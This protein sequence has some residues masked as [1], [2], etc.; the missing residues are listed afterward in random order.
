[1]MRRTW[2]RRSAVAILI[3]ASIARGEPVR[4][5]WLVGGP[6]DTVA[7][8]CAALSGWYAFADSFEDNVEVYDID[9]QQPIRTITKQEIQALVPGGLDGGPNGPCALAWSDS[10]RIL[11]ILV[12]NLSIDGIIAY[13]TATDTMA[14]FA[15]LP[16]YN[17]NCWPHLAAVH[18]RGRLYVGTYRQGIEVYQ[19]GANDVEGTL[20]YAVT[21]PTG[22][23]VHGLAVDREAN[24]LYA[25]DG[26]NIYRA[27]L[28][29]DP[30]QSEAFVEVGSI[31]NVVA[32]TFSDH[33]GG[34]GNEGLYVL[35]STFPFASAPSC[36][37]D[38]DYYYRLHH[39]PIAQARGQEPFK[40]TVYLS[41]SESLHDIAATACGRLVA[42][43]SENAY[44][45]SDDT[46]TS[47]L[48][49]ES[50]L[51]DEFD[52]VVNFGKS[53]IVPDDE[54]LPACC[55][56]NMPAGW[57][58]DAD[59]Q[60][61]WCRFHPVTPDGAAW[62]TLLL[63]MNEQ[64]NGDPEAKHLV[65]L[66]LERYAGMAEDGIVPES[67]ADGHF[68]HW[69]DPATGE[70]K[71][72]LPECGEDPKRPCWDPEFAVLSTMKMVVAASRA[73][74][75]YPDDLR[76]QS[77][78]LRL[79]CQVKNWD[80]Y[81]EPGTDCLFLKALAEGGPDP[82]SAVCPF[83]E[84]IIFVE[85]AANYGG[86]PSQEAFARWLDR[87]L[88]PSAE[89]VTGK[90]ITGNIPDEFQSAFV[91]LYPFLLQQP[92][93]ASPDWQAQIHNMRCSYA[94]WTDDNG[95]KYYTV[96]SAGTTKPEWSKNGSG[97]NAD[98]LSNHP[99]DI[100]TFPSLMA[101]CATG[102]SPEAVAAYHAYRHAARQTFA[103]GASILYRR[104]DEDPGYKPNSAGLPDVALGALGLAELLQPGS[105]DAVLALAYPALN[106][107][108][109]DGVSDCSDVCPATPS[110]V[111]AVDDEGRPL[112]D[113]DHD[114]DADLLDFRLFQASFTGPIYP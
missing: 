37:P 91:S 57:V 15:E 47:R 82:S 87:G 62:V 106:D 113:L 54:A 31:T 16:L 23:Y 46:D 41:G 70:L 4:E 6:D 19:A 88:W 71:C 2:R 20:L 29:T 9:H 38:P 81:I 33:Y 111:G 34:T 50:W 94:A 48:S 67:S 93:R 102:K 21:L 80:A 101:L 107:L 60:Q 40:P 112:G 43:R 42:G 75:R 73:M 77:A 32:I 68:R 58:V 72:P 110:D 85:Q 53:L 45:I 13:N 98:N 52:Q 44:L 105:V 25:T 92:Y 79:I 99:G 22:S 69:M 17:R 108:D 97:Y 14:L 65:R 74:A 3:C 39:V 26:S 114:C 10:G 86:T 109:G 36:L 18:F 76:I 66:I 59:V 8:A 104:S 64:I 5:T 35:E 83:F 12:H 1:M 11:Y 89:Y 78:G 7:T 28:N 24:L 55:P 96:F 27:D 49:F 95:P 84:G 30:L 103:G 63:M 56:D 100:T 51:Q 90:P 61:T